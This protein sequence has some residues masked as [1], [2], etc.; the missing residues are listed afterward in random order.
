LG[1]FSKISNGRTHYVHACIEYYAGN[2]Y[3]FLC[4]GAAGRFLDMQR[5]EQRLLADRE[6]NEIAVSSHMDG[7][8]NSPWMRSLVLEGTVDKGES[9]NTLSDYDGNCAREIVPARRPWWMQS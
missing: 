9:A 7:A 1:P 6:G 4:A 2:G 3:A 5:C 8:V